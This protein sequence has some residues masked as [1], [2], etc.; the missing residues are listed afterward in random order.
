VPDP[1]RCGHEPLTAVDRQSAA[2][3]PGDVLYHAR[4]RVYYTKPA[5]RGWL[6]L[7]WFGVSLV[8]APLLTP[9][10]GHAMASAPSGGR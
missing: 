6:H 1:A 7:L 9:L 2:P 8:A 3:L 10:T 4:R 5:L